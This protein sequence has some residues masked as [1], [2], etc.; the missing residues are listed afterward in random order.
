MDRISPLLVLGTGS[1][2]ISGR[3]FK[4]T[5]AHAMKNLLGLVYLWKFMSARLKQNPM[6]NCAHAR[7]APNTTPLRSRAIFKMLS[8]D[9]NI[10]LFFQ[11]WLFWVW[12]FSWKTIWK[13]SLCWYWSSLGCITFKIWSKYEF[14][15]LILII[16]QI[17]YHFF[18]L[19]FF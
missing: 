13:K 6:P 11:L 1:L 9:T 14:R 3:P 7:P 5:Y 15:I 10:L 19:V 2:L 17:L 12:S 8:V 4:K 16:L 18:T